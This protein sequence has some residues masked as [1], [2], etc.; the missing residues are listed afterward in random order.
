[1][2]FIRLIFDVVLYSLLF[3]YPDVK[4]PAQ[5]HSDEN[6]QVWVFGQPIDPA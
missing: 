3:I 6:L 5:H 2:D 1:M 4:L